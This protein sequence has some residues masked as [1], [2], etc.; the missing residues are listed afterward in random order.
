MK[1][2]NSL[3]VS[4]HIKM[5]NPK[6]SYLTHRLSIIRIKHNLKLNNNLF[7]TFIKPLYRLGYSLLINCSNKER[8][9][10]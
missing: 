4:H 1:L 9:D 10:F 6:I 2:H 5:I 7:S 8:I 3:D